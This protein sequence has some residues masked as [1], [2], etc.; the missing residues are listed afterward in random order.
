MIIAAHIPI[1]VVGRGDRDG[2]VGLRRGPGREARGAN[3]VSLTELVAKLQAT[4]NLL[5]WLAGHRHF[6]AVKAF[7]PID[8]LERD[9]APWKGFWQVE[10][11]SL[12]D[13]PSSS[14][15]SR[16]S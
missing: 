15:P 2:M 16:S 11:S 14:A 7:P 13:F 4:P 12:R 1:G 6:N 10:T 9:S 3:A 5:V 8:P